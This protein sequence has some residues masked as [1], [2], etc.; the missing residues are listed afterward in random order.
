MGN[1]GKIYPLMEGGIYHLVDA[2]KPLRALQYL[3]GNS[4]TLYLW[5]QK[6]I[7]PHS[8][9]ATVAIIGDNLV[10]DDVL[11]LLL[12]E[13]GYNTLLLAEPATDKLEQLL[14][15]VQ[16]LILTPPRDVTRR[17]AFLSTAIS[18]QTMTKIPVLELLTV[19][20]DGE[21]TTSPGYSVGWPCRIEELARQIEAALLAGPPENGR[22]SSQVGS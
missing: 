16:L 7:G 20:A 12:Q 1:P 2:R 6:I 21:Q 8:T 11:K 14:V 17:K 19:P 5:R 9:P 4:G 22:N 10:V 13:A 18:R 3:F 15:D